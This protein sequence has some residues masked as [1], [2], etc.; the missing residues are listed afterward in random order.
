MQNRVSNIQLSEDLQHTVYR[1][2]ISVCARATDKCIIIWC[3]MFDFGECQS[4]W[5]NGNGKLV[6]N[7]CLSMHSDNFT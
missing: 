4:I 5:R 3:V 7:N 6:V 1:I 2:T